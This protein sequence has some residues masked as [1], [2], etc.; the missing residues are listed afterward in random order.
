MLY[1]MRSAKIGAYEDSIKKPN[2]DGWGFPG[3]EIRLIDDN[4]NEGTT[5]EIG[6]ILLRGEGGTL[7]YFND[8]EGTSCLID[9]EKGY[10]TGDLAYKDAGGY[11][12]FCD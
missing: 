6:E 8:T 12:Y 2:T 4:G 7:G 3:V 11:Y 10:R 5:G 1:H 9:R